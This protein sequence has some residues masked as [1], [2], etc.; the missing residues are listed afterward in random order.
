MARD[1]LF[2]KRQAGSRSEPDGRVSTTPAGDFPRG[3]GRRK[4]L[5]E[6]L[7]VWR[8][9]TAPRRKSPIL[10]AITTRF[11]PMGSVMHKFV[12]AIFTLAA[13]VSAADLAAGPSTK[14]PA[15]AT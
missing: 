5:C 8:G 15:P 2:R 9:D 10:R 3:W 14:A 7:P 1:L 6:F 13:G 12:G 4:G 11:G